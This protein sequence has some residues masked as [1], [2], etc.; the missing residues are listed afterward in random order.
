MSVVG[1]GVGLVDLHA[2][3]AHRLDRALAVLA[4][5]K[6]RGSRRRRCSGR[7]TSPRDGK[8]SCR[9]ARWISAWMSGAR[10]TRISEG[11]LLAHVP[12]SLLESSGMEISVAC[13]QRFR[14]ALVRYQT[15]PSAVSRD[16]WPR[17]G[18]F[19][20]QRR[21]RPPNTSS[22][23]RSLSINPRSAFVTGRGCGSRFLS[24]IPAIPPAIRVMSRQPGPAQAAA[25]ARLRAHEIHQRR[26][27]HVRQVAD[28]RHGSRRARRA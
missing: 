21:G 11:S 19:R 17:Q 4:R 20:A 18:I 14:P 3:R 12:F 6:L 27:Q 28:Q 5:T 1:S 15:L 8:C 9:P 13:V 7:R 10:R 26:R 25:F 22:T 24:I 2:Q 16:F 23:A